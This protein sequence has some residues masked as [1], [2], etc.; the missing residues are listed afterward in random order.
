MS[1]QVEKYNNLSLSVK[2]HASAVVKK[3]LPSSTQRA[4]SQLVNVSPCFSTK[5]ALKKWICS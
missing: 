4:N 1:T 5:V 2:K 3:L